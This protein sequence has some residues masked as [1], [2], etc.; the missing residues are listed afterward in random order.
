MGMRKLALAGGVAGAVACSQFPEF[1]QQYL[2]RLAGQ[3]DALTQVQSDFDATASKAGYTRDQAL[4]EL[5]GAGFVGAQGDMMRLTFTRLERLRGDLALLRSAA[6]LER[7]AMP[8]RLA[9]RDLLRAT[10]ADFKPAVPV[11]SEGF[12]AAGVGYALGWVLVMGVLA[13]LGR[14]VRRR[15]VA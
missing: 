4:A 3:V 14:V 5:S 6:P 11:T 13:L 12:I 2:Q 9:D 1:S 15:R 8:H 10:W 7:M